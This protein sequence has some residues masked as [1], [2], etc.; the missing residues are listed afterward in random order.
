LQSKTK[1]DDSEI[2]KPTVDG[3]LQLIK[4]DSKLINFG[5]LF[6][7]LVVLDYP[8]DVQAFME[9]VGKQLQTP[10]TTKDCGKDVWKNPMTRSL[11][12]CVVGNYCSTDYNVASKEIITS[13]IDTALGDWH[14]GAAQVRQAASSF[15]YNYVL[16]KQEPNQEIDDGDDVMISIL[17]SSLENVMTETDATTRLRQ[18]ALCGRLVFPTHRN[19]NDMAKCLVQDLGFVDSLQEIAN[20]DI[21]SCESSSKEDAKQCQELAVELASKM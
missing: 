4:D 16:S 11:A 3:L 2:V 17:C 12:W 19:V 9:W 10:L 1:L 7:R 15:L 21:S 14:N 18:L 5:L 13:L 20:Q 8:N 6:F